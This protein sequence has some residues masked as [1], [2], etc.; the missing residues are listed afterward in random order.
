MNASKRGTLCPA[1]HFSIPQFD[2]LASLER[3]SGEK[4]GAAFVRWVDAYMLPDPRIPCTGIDVYAARCGV[5][6]SFS[7]DSDLSRQGRARKLSYVWGDVDVEKLRR[8]AQA[9]NQSIV[10]VHVRDLI[11]AFSAGVI[12]YIDEVTLDAKNHK[13]FF[14]GC[15]QWL[16]GIEK[17]LIDD[18]LEIHSQRTN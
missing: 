11:D 7:A 17:S 9:L 13:Q 4:G 18:F 12:K 1:S 16:L 3:A 14:E 8:A 10:C 15:G 2:V 5:I 6:H